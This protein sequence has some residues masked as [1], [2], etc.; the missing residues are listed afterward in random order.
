MLKH[1]VYLNKV[2]ISTTNLEN[3]K[4]GSYIQL[5]ED[6][7]PLPEGTLLLLGYNRNMV[8]LSNP[9]YNWP[10]ASP[11]L[12]VRVLTQGECINIVIGSE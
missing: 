8:L 7:P 2:S 9:T 11:K 12:K 6:C 4:E 5:K 3:V 1:E 10:S